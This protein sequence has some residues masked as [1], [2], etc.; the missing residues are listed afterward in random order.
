LFG[1]KR[2]S[3]FQPN[4][5]DEDEFFVRLSPSL[6]DDF[7]LGVGSSIAGG[8]LRSISYTFYARNLRL[9]RLLR[10]WSLHSFFFQNALAYFSG[11]PL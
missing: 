8:G 1:E 3:L 10:A 7:G 2:S 9:D 6:A 5:C 4:I 11:A